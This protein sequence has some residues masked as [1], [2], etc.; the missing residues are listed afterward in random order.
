MTAPPILSRPLAPRHLPET[1][2]HAPVSGPQ[3]AVSWQG[4]QNRSHR[5]WG[6]SQ[7]GRKPDKPDV[8]A[9]LSARTRGR[10]RWV[11]RPSGA[12]AEGRVAVGGE[13]QHVCL[14]PV[15]PAEHALDEVEHPAREAAGEQDRGPR[16]DG[17]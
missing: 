5:C 7:Y 17:E 16:R 15:R 12:Q 2:L 3:S 13:Q 9:T 8:P 10:A 14:H 4:K 1:G 6:V 11:V